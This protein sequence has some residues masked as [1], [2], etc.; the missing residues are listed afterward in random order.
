MVK[1]A[2]T[3]EE[4]LKECEHSQCDNHEFHCVSPAGWGVSLFSDS[5]TWCIMTSLCYHGVSV[6]LAVRN[7]SEVLLAGAVEHDQTKRLKR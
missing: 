1:S 7:I 2:N 4:R 5:D 6:R 3:I